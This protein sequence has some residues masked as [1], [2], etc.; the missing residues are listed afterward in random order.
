MCFFLF[1]RF[2]AIELVTLFDS[3]IRL[4]SP[5]GTRPRLILDE[6]WLGFDHLISKVP[7]YIR[8]RDDFID[9][10]GA[11]PWLLLIDQLD[12]FALF[13]E[14]GDELVD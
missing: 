11:R 6:R 13:L 7:L 12:S 3:A 14:L 1:R 2:K 9:N 10:I 5:E 4:R 8:L